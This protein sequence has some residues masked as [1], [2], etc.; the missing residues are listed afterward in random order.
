MVVVNYGSSNGVLL[1]DAVGP[2][3]DDSVDYP[4]TELFT[5]QQYYH[6][7]QLHSTGLLVSV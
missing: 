4:L 2:N 3:G 6:A 1:S 5:N 7:A